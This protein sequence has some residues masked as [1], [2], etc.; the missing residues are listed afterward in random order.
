MKK[1]IQITAGKGPE[2]C[3][4]LVARLVTLLLKEAADAALLAAVLE[5]EKGSKKGTLSSVLI[6]V[7]GKEDVLNAFTRSWEGSVLWIGNSPFRKNHKRKNWFVGVYLIDLQ[8]NKTTLTETDIQYQVY[9]GSGP[10]GQHANKV[11]S[12]VRAIH[13]PTGY[14]AAASESRSQQQNKKKAKER[15]IQL[16]SLKKLAQERETAQGKWRNHLQLE[17]G[18]PNRTFQGS[19]FKEV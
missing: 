19:R 1:C 18:N 9:R 10:G 16:I 12:A 17:R 4:W 7:N 5:Q 3:C 14:S 15:L 8:T 11:S 2:E 6:E 13:L